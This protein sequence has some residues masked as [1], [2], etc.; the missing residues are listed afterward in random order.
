M[1]LVAS[2][3]RLLD[4]ESRPHDDRA[5]AGAI[6]CLDPGAAEDQACRGEVRS[7]NEAD[8]II[9]ARVGV[10]KQM[11]GGIDDLAEVVRGN[12]RRHTDGDSIR[13]VDEEVGDARRQDRGLLQAIVEVRDEIDALFVEIVEKLD[14]ELG[15]ARLRVSVCRR[16][17][18]V[19]RAVVSLSVDER[20]AHRKALR[21][22]H[23]RVV[24]GCVAV[25]VVL[26][27]HVADD[28]RALSVAGRREQALLVRTVEDAAVHGLE[29]VANVGDSSADDDAHRV[30]E[31][32]GAHLVLDRDGDFLL[33]RCGLALVQQH[34]QHEVG[35]MHT[36]HRQDEQHGEVRRAENEVHSQGDSQAPQDNCQR[37]V[38]RCTRL[39]AGSPVRARGRARARLMI[40]HMQQC[41]IKPAAQPPVSV[42]RPSGSGP[43]C[44][45]R[46]TAVVD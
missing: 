43:M 11:H 12:V 6:R 37:L 32:R 13:A 19:D 42:P 22:P 7:R 38:F 41:V 34:G 27:E 1:L 23:H 5:A 28:G 4:P 45:T 14:R 18:T 31:V 46:A 40:G 26:A 35:S 24:N 29:P 36:I 30:V 2:T 15:E 44:T 16:R 10:A 8:E 25:R 33:R 20:V 39:S 17:V 21:E 9:E 3:R